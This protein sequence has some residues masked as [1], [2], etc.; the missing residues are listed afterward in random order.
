VLQRSSFGFSGTY[1]DRRFFDLGDLDSTEIAGGISFSR[2]I[3][4]I[5][6]LGVALTGS[7][8]EYADSSNEYEIY[9]AF[10]RYESELASGAVIIDVGANR[11]EDQ[12]SE[13][14]SDTEPMFRLSWNRDVATRSNLTLG[15]QRQIVDLGSSIVPGSTSGLNQ[16]RPGRLTPFAQP[17][18]ES[19][20]DVGFNTRTPVTDFSIGAGYS[21]QEFEQ[22][23][24]Q[25]QDFAFLQLRVQ[26]SIGR[27]FGVSIAP[28]F[29][30][31]ETE[32]VPD[33]S[34]EIFV[35][36]SFFK[37]FRRRV[38]VGIS[39]QYF[40]RAGDPVTAFRE[41]QYRIDLATLFRGT[42]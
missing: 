34:D 24:Q 28:Q 29:R 38:R 30:T 27:G 16:Q 4:P 6:K 14:V 23:L 37:D 40:D 2:Q 10:A 7:H 22:D 3:D 36:A 17:F 1:G 15:V 42:R 12:L 39:Y 21:E 20:V 26:R 11:V 13:R 18:E 33:R 8:I 25:N 19:R 35:T 31:I 9:R 32:G 41:N 5:R